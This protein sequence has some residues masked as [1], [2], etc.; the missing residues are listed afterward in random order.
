MHEDEVTG[1]AYDSRLAKRLFQYL[2]PY[3]LYILLGTLSLLASSACQLAGPYLVKVGIDK[4]I[5]PGELDGFTG[6]IMI[7]LGII[8]VD[9]FFRFSQIY[10]TNY[11]GQKTMYDLRMELFQHLQRLSLRFFDRNPVGRLV[12][13]AT[14]DVE[15]LNQLFSQ[16]LVTVIG[17]L[18]MIGGIMIAMLL[19][20]AK[21]ALLTFSILPVLLV[22]TFYFRRRMR[23]AFRMVRTRIA[24][25]NA[26][27]QEALSGMMVIQ[28]FN[29]QQRTEDR[30][31]GLNRDHME[32]YLQTIFYYALFYPLVELIGTVALAIIIWHGGLSVM[33]GT[34]TFGVLVAFIQYVEKF[35]KPI[36]DLSEKYNIFQAAAASSERIFALLDTKEIIED[37]EQPQWLDH[38]EGKVEFRDVHFA[39]NPG[40]PVLKGISFTAK[41]GEKIAIVGS[42]GAGKTTIINLL[43]RFYDPQEGRVSIDGHDIREFDKKWLRQNIGIALQDVF[44]FSGSISGNIALGEDNPSAERIRESVEAIGASPFIERLPGGYEHVLTE[45]GS[46]LSQGQRQL[47]SFARVMYKNPRIL[48]LDEATSS[49]DTHTEQM[50]Q[51]ALERL[52]SGRTSLIIAHRLSTIRHV[53]RIIVMHHG[54]I[55]E[56]GTHEELLK[57]GGIYSNLYQLQYKDQEVPVSDSG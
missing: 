47:L 12:T 31:D 15:V 24:R 10:I 21:L 22:V 56:E 19:L 39:Y 51:K 2:R 30:F 1:K 29:R 4:Y 8:A 14:T 9:F 25:I 33:E 57:A 44:I 45:R 6:L 42:T 38:V 52:I 28:L 7:Y 48:V 16:G 18:A 5:V 26:F 55:A 35:F 37:P 49:V 3:W 50:I 13:R 54:R 11:L 43:A 34:L 23:E 53:D 17:D 36:S 46:T 27:L 40:E 20:N 32:A 41:P